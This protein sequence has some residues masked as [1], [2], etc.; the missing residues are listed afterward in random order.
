MSS[1]VSQG[2]WI[3]FLVLVYNAQPDARNS[4]ERAHPFGGFAYIVG[5]DPQR[6]SKAMTRSIPSV[7]DV[8]K[9]NIRDL[10]NAL[11]RTLVRA[12]QIHN[13]P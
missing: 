5:P 6:Q 2:L 1:K 12:P 13:R 8:S 7:F 9:G 4:I 10:V 3:D 11:Y